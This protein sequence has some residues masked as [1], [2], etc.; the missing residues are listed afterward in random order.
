MN[1]YG[2]DKS[3]IS[4]PQRLQSINFDETRLKNVIV[5]TQECFY[6]LKITEINRR[7]QRYLFKK[8]ISYI[9]CVHACAYT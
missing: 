3:N 2:R 6:N 1:L 7:I 4:L 5:N 8:I 9:M